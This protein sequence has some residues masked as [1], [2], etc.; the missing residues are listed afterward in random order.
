MNVKLDGSRTST[1]KPIRVLI[2]APALPIVGGQTVQAIRLIEAFGEEIGVHVDLQ[3]INPQFLPALQKVKYLRT[4]LTSTKYL[5]DLLV[6]TPRYDI[7]HIFSASYFSFLLSPTPAVLV[8]RLYGKKTI[9]NYRS[10]E[11]DDH[12]K[13]W[14]HTAVLT[15]RL[16]DKIV[17]PSG[18]LVDVFRKFGLSAEAIF[19]FVDTGRFRFRER[20]PLLPVFLSNRNFESHYN[21]SCT[22]RAFALIQAAIP[23]ASLIVAGDGPEK[24]MLHSLASDLNLQN[25]YFI[26]RVSPTEMPALYHEA[27]V[28]LNSPNID[29]MPNSIIEAFACGL[30]VVSTNAGGIPYIVNSGENGLLVETADHHGLAESA[31]SLFRSKGLAQS[32]IGAAQRDVRKYSWENVRDEWLRTYAELSR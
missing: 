24:A 30:P 7:I 1:K 9:L 28:F 22:L 27:D 23:E 13:T 25:T 5:F 15:I 14:K 26:G 8:A 20:N 16:F 4:I 21:V 2:V 6:K 32:L 12:L 3:P 10:G 18:Y 11:A 19:N 17:T 29:N 31:L